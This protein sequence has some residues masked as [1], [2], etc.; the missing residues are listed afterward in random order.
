MVDEFERINVD[1]VE[2]FVKRDG[3]IY[4]RLLTYPLSCHVNQDGDKRTRLLT[5]DTAYNG[6]VWLNLL[7]DEV[8]VDGIFKT[9]L[10][11]SFYDK[12][13]GV[14]AS[15]PIPMGILYLIAGRRERI[16][17]VRPIKSIIKET[18]KD[19]QENTK[20]IETSK[21]KYLCEN[22]AKGVKTSDLKRVIEGLKNKKIEMK[23]EVAIHKDESK[24][25][26]DKFHDAQDKVK[27]FSKMMSEISKPK[28][29]G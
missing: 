8:S 5:Q 6:T 25:N 23:Q 28:I 10:K 2:V 18:I 13:S 9:N 21:Y 12:K 16:P 22:G 15:I 26:V 17:N 3:S 4:K 20:I 11:I 19:E 24:N 14:H 29:N 7:A 27:E 1:G